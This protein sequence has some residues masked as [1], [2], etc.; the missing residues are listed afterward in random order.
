MQGR[1]PSWKFVHRPLT[2]SQQSGKERSTPDGAEK[3]YPY[4]VAQLHPFAV[5]GRLLEWDDVDPVLRPE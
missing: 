4:F 2:P 1:A 5:A 3:G